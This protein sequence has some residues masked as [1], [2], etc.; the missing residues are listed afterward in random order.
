M[1]AFHALEV[2]VKPAH[3][4]CVLV[5]SC[6]LLLAFAAGMA[7]QEPTTPKR[8]GIPQDWSDRHII[9]SR[10]ALLAHPEVMTREPR[11]FHQALQRF[12]APHS[13]VFPVVPHLPEPAKTSQ[14]DWNVILGGRLAANVYPAKYSFDASQ[15]P[16]CTNDFVVFPLSTTG[17]TGGRPNLVG[18]NNLYAGTGGM[19]T[20]GPSVLFAYNIT[21]VTGGK[22]VTSPILSLDG[23]KIAFVEST[24][25]SAIFH[26]LTWASGAGTLAAAV[27][28]TK[29]TSLTFSPTANSTTSSPWIDYGNDVVYVGADNS[30]I[31]KIT[32][33]FTGTP[34][35]AGAPWPVTVSTNFR[36]TAPVLDLSRNV[37]MVGSANGSLYQ[38][39]ITTGATSAYVIG[40]S[41]GTSPGIAATPVVDVTNG[42]TFAV[43]ANDGTSGVIVEVDT[44]SL[45]SLAKARIGEAAASTTAMNLY[46]P[47]FSNDY[48]NNPSSGVLRT[49]GTGAN[50]ITPWQYAFPFTG[51]IM[52]SS[53][54]FSKQLLTSTNARCTG[55]NEFFNP[56]IGGAAGTDYFFFGLTEDCT[57]VTGYAGGCVAEITNT[58]T[59]PVF[60]N[61]NGGP[62]GIVV[63]N[64]STA[65]Q[66]S[67]IYFSAE[68][69]DTVYKLTQN[70]LQ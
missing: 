35:L 14:R 15:P 42:T 60:V 47:A 38:I 9:F 24:G 26:V 10:D 56:N 16:S 55:W 2:P 13:D 39:N 40:K 65:G 32:N 51:R 5:A 1:S 4:Y 20:T 66:A 29:M 59:T 19:C 49:C 30:E 44:T 41:G 17:V 68:K 18:F 46:E 8:I 70:G 11:V 62:S 48:F 33:V 69:V 36:L 58:N 7:A 57:A 45:T 54:S 63:D 31:Y 37:L 27:A 52:S 28:P 53:S 12:Q 3:P 25:S 6:V 21:T 34:K 67:S 64:Y 23:T 50:D 22:I 43:S 61:I